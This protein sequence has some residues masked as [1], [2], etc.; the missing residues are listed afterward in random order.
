MK[1]S[2][3][4]IVLVCFA[5][6]VI[7]TVVLVTPLFAM[8]CTASCG[9]NGSVSCSGESCEA[10]NGLGCMAWEGGIGRFESCS[11]GIE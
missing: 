7:D 2:R 8:T 1:T 11:K 6:L 4:V 9:E 10:I 5:L 3:I